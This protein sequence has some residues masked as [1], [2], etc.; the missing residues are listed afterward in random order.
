MRRSSAISIDRRSTDP[1]RSLRQNFRQWLLP[2]VFARAVAALNTNAEGKAWLTERQL[3]DLHEQILR[4]PNLTLL[5]ANEAIQK[6]LFKAQVDVNELTGEQDPVVKLINF[7]TARKPRPLGWR[8]S[9]RLFCTPPQ[10][11]EYRSRT[12]QCQG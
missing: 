3:Q 10:S 11:A 12:A 8:R 5:E 6:L 1:G 7:A 2:E 9:A 4:Q